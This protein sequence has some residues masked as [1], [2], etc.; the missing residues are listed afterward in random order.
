MKRWNFLDSDT[1][2]M[3]ILDCWNHYVDVAQARVHL[4]SEKLIGNKNTH[5]FDLPS[6]NTAKVAECSKK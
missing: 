5:N 6:A 1:V 4:L 3:D 2:R